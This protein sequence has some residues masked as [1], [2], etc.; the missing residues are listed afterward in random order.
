MNQVQKSETNHKSYVQDLQYDFYGNR[1]ATCAADEHIKI[2]EK[3]TDGQWKCTYDWKAHNGAIYKIQWAHPEFGQV[4]ASCSEDRTCQIWEEPPMEEKQP[5]LLPQQQQQQ[6]QQPISFHSQI[7]NTM[8]GGGG[9][10]NSNSSNIA[11]GAS[12]TEGVQPRKWISKASLVDSPQSIIDIKFAPKHHGLKLAT[13]SSDGHVRIYEALD[14]MNLS[15]WSVNQEFDAT[16]RS[17]PAYLSWNPSRFEEPMLA[18]GSH[19]GQI[20]IKKCDPNIRRWE[21]ILTLKA[22]DEAITDIAWA[23]NLGRSYHL[24]ATASKDGARI[25]KIVKEKNDSYRE[26][27]SWSL[28]EHQAEVW[29]VEW[30]LTGTLLATSGDNGYFKLYHFV[31]NNWVPYQKINEVSNDK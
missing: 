29:K 2:F 6:Q 17:G 30:N 5:P 10:S 12:S 1:I 19:D 14:V 24:I 3:T 27:Y 25:T 31:D 28:K 21:K 11:T 8:T 4:L 9:S 7:N 13:C 16:D 15:Y 22:H 18:I 20:T 26:A 23:P